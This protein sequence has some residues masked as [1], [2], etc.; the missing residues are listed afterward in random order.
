MKTLIIFHKQVHSCL[1]S[2]STNDVLLKQVFETGWPT[3]V[4]IER[5]EVDG[6][7]F[8]FGESLSAISMGI[9]PLGQSNILS[10][11]FK[12]DKTFYNAGP[13]FREFHESLAFRSLVSRY[14]EQGWKKELPPE[15]KAVQQRIWEHEEALRTAERMELGFVIPKWES[16]LPVAAYRGALS[17]DLFMEPSLQKYLSGGGCHGYIGA[18]ERTRATDERLEQL[19]KERGF[20]TA[21]IATFLAHSDGRYFADQLQG[22]DDVNEYLDQYLPSR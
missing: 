7:P 13:P 8:P 6:I 10:I 5:C 1:A 17:E 9:D 3:E 4:S 15:A 19:C 21:E 16:G 14:E 20:T 22:P 2:F 12:A 18:S 11:Y